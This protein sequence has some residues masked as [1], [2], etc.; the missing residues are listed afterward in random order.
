MKIGIIFAIFSWEGTIPRLKERSMTCLSGF[1]MVLVHF[2]RKY[3]DISFKS[4]EVLDSRLAMALMISSWL[5]CKSA[6]LKIG[7]F[8]GRALGLSPRLLKKGLIWSATEPGAVEKNS[9][10]WFAS[11]EGSVYDRPLMII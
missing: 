2:L 11:C 9:L 5:T 3:I 8:T 10:N 7:I 4:S 1:K 6:D